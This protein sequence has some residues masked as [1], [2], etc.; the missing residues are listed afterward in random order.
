MGPKGLGF[1]SLGS[2]PLGEGAEW[3]S[4]CTTVFCESGGEGSVVKGT[5]V[6]GGESLPCCAADMVMEESR[7]LVLASNGGL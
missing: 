2:L 3:S 4:S 5:S 6:E 1:S 7:F